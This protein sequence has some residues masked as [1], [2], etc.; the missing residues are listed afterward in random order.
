MD[1]PDDAGIFRISDDI[2]MIQTVDFFT[3]IVDDPYDFG[4]I[5]AANSLSDIFAMGGKPA[6][7]LNI[8]GFPDTRLD[9]EVLAQILLGGYDKAKEAGVSIL[10]GHSVKDPE[11]KY[12]LAVTGFI[13]PD[14]IIRNNTARPGDRLI[15]TKPLGTGILTTALKN[16][17]L[18]DE[19]LKLITQKMKRLNK[20]AAE[21]MKKF[22]ANACTDV[23]GYG[24]IGH[25]HEMTAGSGVTARIELNAVPLLPDCVRLAK[26]RK[27][28]GGLKD[29][30]KFAAA[31]VRPANHLDSAA[32]DVLFDPQ[33]SGGLIIS[34]PADNAE[35]CLK[36]L[37]EN[38]EDAAIVGEIVPRGE[39]EIEVV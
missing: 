6:T 25:L 33:T 31:F 4:Q 7:A 9:T 35:L 20:N 26:K 30:R 1:A 32:M 5:A 28:P 27:V 2:G 11:L 22:G 24:F 14:K 8:V 16:G 10:G 29:N 36:A 3:P 23:T 34:L 21:A 15:L 18:S 12:G 17:K 39:T 38:G 19:L 37:I 13:H